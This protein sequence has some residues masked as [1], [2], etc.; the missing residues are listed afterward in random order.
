MN[1]YLE[2]SSST[3]VAKKKMGLAKC[4]AKT[5]VSGT[6][7]TSSLLRGQTHSRESSGASNLSVKYTITQSSDGGSPIASATVS[8]AGN[9]PSH[10]ATQERLPTVSIVG[11][12]INTSN[13]RRKKPRT[14]RRNATTTSTDVNEEEQ[15]SDSLSAGECLDDEDVGEGQTK[16][17]SMVNEAYGKSCDSLNNERLT[18]H[19]ER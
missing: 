10:E 19:K 14:R 17:D 7:D 15:L 4:A 13:H 1:F 9:T 8:S 18:P 5:E 16:E 6:D 11:D 3:S 2:M 12:R